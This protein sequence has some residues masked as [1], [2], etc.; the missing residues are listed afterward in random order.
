MY[1]KPSYYPTQI[2]VQICVK[3]K[4]LSMKGENAHQ[5]CRNF[6]NQDTLSAYR[7]RL[8]SE[9]YTVTLSAWLYH[10]RYESYAKCLTEG[11][12]WALGPSLHRYPNL[13]YSSPLC[14]TGICLGQ[15]QMPLY[16]LNHPMLPKTV[17]NLCK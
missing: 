4:K 10:D 17:E 1:I 11:W 13:Q 6:S 15:I 12:S 2:D 9:E 3:S 8:V 7:V 14:K 5:L 16:I